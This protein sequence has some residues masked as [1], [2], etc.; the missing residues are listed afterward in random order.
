MELGKK[1]TLFQLNNGVTIPLLG[2][3]TFRVSENG[4]SRAV[5]EALE[6]GYRHIDAAAVY[7]NEEEVGNG[8]RQSGVPRDQ[9]FVTSK[10]WNSERG[11]QATLKAFD[12]TLSDLQLDYLDLYL[13]HWPANE[14]QFGARWEDLNADTWK[15]LEELL[16]KKRVRAIGV[17]NFLPH[18]LESLMKRSKVKPAVNQIELNPGHQQRETV[19]F[20]K[21]NQILVEAWGPLGQGRLLQNSTL[22]NIGKK[23]GKS[24]AQ[25]CV[26]WILQQ[27]I[28]PLVKSVTPQRIKENFD[29]WDFTLTSEDMQAISALPKEG[30]SG[31]DPDQVTF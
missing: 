22:S 2:Y 18:H 11:Y 20:C 19:D 30:F 29:V 31:L 24:V 7:D 28:S 6:V 25:V 4:A 21:K 26:R 8:I 13:I 16:S 23:Y 12:R 17:S 27:D 3:G 1:Q 5:R 15:A 10:V 14:R 9:I